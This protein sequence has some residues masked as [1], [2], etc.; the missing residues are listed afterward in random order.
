MHRASKVRARVSTWNVLITD[1]PDNQTPEFLTN[2]STSGIKWEDIWCALAPR[3][4]CLRTSTFTHEFSVGRPVM[5]PV[6]SEYPGE[7][8]L[9]AHQITQDQG[10]YKY[11]MMWLLEIEIVKASATWTFFKLLQISSFEKYGQQYLMRL[12]PGINKLTHK[13]LSTVSHLQKV[14]YKPPSLFTLNNPSFFHGR[15]NNEPSKRV[16]NAWSL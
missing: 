9:P 8:L 1:Q 11:N 13:V 16:L 14:L 5:T 6:E 4:G 10:G 7:L 12:L 2:W 3:L 15:L